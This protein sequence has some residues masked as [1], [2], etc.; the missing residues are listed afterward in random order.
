MSTRRTIL[1]TPLPQ[2]R[3][4][5]RVQALIIELRKLP[6]RYSTE[7]EAGIAFITAMRKDSD[8]FKKADTLRSYLLTANVVAEV[9]PDPT[10]IFG[11]GDQT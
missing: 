4:L 1:T 11:P 3:R 9:S 8:G 6:A 5:A 2:S 7:F 10:V